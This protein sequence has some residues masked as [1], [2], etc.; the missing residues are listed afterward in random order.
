[1][2]GE[3]EKASAS[4][5][6]ASA[7]RRLVLGFAALCLAAA[8]QAAQAAQTTEPPGL[9][10]LP[11]VQFAPSASLPADDGPAAPPRRI[12]VG[13]L[14]YSPPWYDGAFVDESVRYLSWRLPRYDFSLRYYDPE[15]LH[16][17][18]RRGKVDL[19]A[20]NATFFLMDP[21]HELRVLASIVSDAA[22]DPNR[23]TAAT[24]IVR[25]DR[26]DISTLADLEGKRIAAVKSEYSPGLFEVLYEA[27]K[28]GRNPDRLF[29]QVEE[30]PRLKMKRVIDDVIEGRADAGIL[31]AC[32][33]EDLW[34]AGN[35]RF[36]DQIRVINEKSDGSLA[37]RHSTALYPGWTI[38][39]AAALPQ[40]AARAVTAVLLT[41]PQNAW[42]QYWSVATD[43]GSAVDMLRTLQVGPYAYLREWT[44]Q[45]IWRDYWPLIAV[46]GAGLLLLFL[47]GVVLERAVVRRTAE[48][49]ELHSRQRDLTEKLDALQRAGAVGQISGIVAHEM[50]Q[51]LA[52]IQNLAR[53]TLRLI[54]DEPQT[55]DEV[56]SAVERISSEAGRGAAIIDRVRAYSQGRS[57]RQPLDFGAA[58]K[59]ALETFQLSGKSRLAKVRCGPI[60]SGILRADP[61]DVELIVV[62]LLSN[63]VEAASR[64]A[65]P[66]AVLSVLHRE[67]DSPEAAGAGVEAPFIELR[68]ADNGPRLS[69][70]AFA[71]LGEAP[72]RTTKASG[73]GLGLMIVKS[74]AESALGRLSFERNIPEGVVAVLRVPLPP[75]DAAMKPAAPAEPSK[76]KEQ[77][78]PGVSPSPHSSDEAAL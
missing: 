57:N 7:L 43:R 28:L 78:E 18:V 33:L 47:R 41:K 55:L 44:L 9:T 61:L 17:A 37:C 38:A 26:S 49:V 72:L 48:L 36:D 53:G 66:E 54:E 76:P 64:S 71:A 51:P 2:A 59:R 40:E 34:R 75:A 65:K 67:K 10:G 56:E 25:S 68:V 30:R 11:P 13:V 31:R 6:R 20:A 3:R 16:D 46:A 52:A 58:A 60:E 62:N 63:A 45:R 77:A 27:A 21:Q 50:K 22:P 29:D 24:V 12:H 5:W 39:S 35:Q 19:V 69:D 15:G 1:M 32:F 8:V 70:E 23:A 42:G 4:A 73:L 74:L 14:A